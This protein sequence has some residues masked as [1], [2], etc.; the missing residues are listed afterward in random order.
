MRSSYPGERHQYLKDFMQVLG[1]WSHFQQVS[2]VVRH[3]S[4]DQ[5]CQPALL[6]EAAEQNLSPQVLVK[7]YTW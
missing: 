1:G 2:R 5:R 4:F 6:F 3:F 7:E